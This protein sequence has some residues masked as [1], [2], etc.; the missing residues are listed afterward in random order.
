MLKQYLQEI[1]YTDTI[2]DVRSARLRALLGKASTNNLQV[3]D[4]SIDLM[5]SN[6]QLDPLS[7]WVNGNEQLLQLSINSGNKRASTSKTNGSMNPNDV[8]KILKLNDVESSQNTDKKSMGLSG[9]G[10]DDTNAA[11]FYDDEDMSEEDVNIKTNGDTDLDTED[12]LKEFAFLSESSSGSDI[13]SSSDWNV[14]K[15]HLSKLTEQYKKDRRS[16]KNAKIEAQHSL[17]NTHRP[18]RSTL[19]AM[20][21]NL[22]DETAE[23]L[24]DSTNS[25][26]NITIIG[27]KTSTN[28]D[29]SPNSAGAKNEKIKFNS[30]N[31]NL[32]CLE[33]D[34][35]ANDSSLGELS[36]LSVGNSINLSGINDET[37]IDV[38]SKAVLLK[39]KNNLFFLNFSLQEKPYQINTHCVATLTLLDA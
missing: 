15:A 28:L 29:L 5:K 13:E 34:S 7:N 2:I 33:D 11:T 31:N 4:H 20:I 14:D 26:T 30:Q 32:F 25:Q 1:G 35:F 37:I 12:A 8:Q 24:N 39:T 18:N 17:V 6:N 9:V 22:T 27:N 16:A 38:S 19:Q 21:A 10:N 23:S 36:R 3:N